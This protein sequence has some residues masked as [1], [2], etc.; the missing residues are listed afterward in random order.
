[1]TS[2]G[3]PDGAG[4]STGYFSLD[5]GNTWQNEGAGWQHAFEVYWH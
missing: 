3:G 5:G 4:S 1:M 2:S